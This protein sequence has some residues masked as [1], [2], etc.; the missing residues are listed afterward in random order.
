MDALYRENQAATRR[1]LPAENKNRGT[2]TKR[3]AS[4]M[5]S[6]TAAPLPETGRTAAALQS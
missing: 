6:A 1:R 3:S 4:A 5:R 2:E